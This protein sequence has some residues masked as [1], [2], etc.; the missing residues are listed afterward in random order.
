MATL[1]EV[2]QAERQGSQ[3]YA[4]NAAIGRLFFSSSASMRLS[5]STSPLP[6]IRARDPHWAIRTFVP[7]SSAIGPL[8][9]TTVVAS[10][11]VILVKTGQHFHKIFECFQEEE[12]SLFMLQTECTALAAALSQVQALF[13]GGSS[14]RTREVP[15]AVLI[16][17]E[18]S[19]TGCT[20]TLFVL[21]E[22]VGKVAGHI[23]LAQIL[24]RK[25]KA[26]YVWKQD[27]VS[28]LV[29]QLRG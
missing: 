29:Q 10:I 13:A 19:L 4:R 26:K 2:T 16:A 11:A 22:E 23:E 3:P 24:E 15:A 20:I 25:Q 17:L 8:N 14:K 21:T 12:Y 6:S 7:L 1:G 5:S 28:S 27:T 9:I 18:L